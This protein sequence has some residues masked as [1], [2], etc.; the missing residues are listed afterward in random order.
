VPPYTAPPG[1]A[2]PTAHPYT[3]ARRGGEGDMRG[4]RKAGRA[5]GRKVNGEIY[6]Y[7]YTYIYIYIYIHI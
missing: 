6:V 5:E 3:E 2:A 7:I 1:H 4:R